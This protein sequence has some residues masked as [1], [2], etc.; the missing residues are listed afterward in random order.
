MPSASGSMDWEDL[1]DRTDL[2]FRDICFSSAMREIREELGQNPIKIKNSGEVNT[3][4]FLITGIY[5]GLIRG[6]K[7]DVAAFGVLDWRLDQLRAQP[8]EIV[9]LDNSP[10]RRFE[11]RTA[12]NTYSVK[13]NSLKEMKAEIDQIWT[14][15]RG[16]SVSLDA[17]IYC[18]KTAIE[19]H[20]EVFGDIFSQGRGGK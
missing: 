14:A 8:N 6:G 17:T 15:R 16:T 2:S 19:N 10:A 7:P 12:A 11:K 5:R 9:D 18:L 1:E 13:V 3:P 4:T 20:P